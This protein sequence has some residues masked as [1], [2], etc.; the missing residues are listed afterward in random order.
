MRQARRPLPPK[1]LR[2]DSKSMCWCSPPALPPQSHVNQQGVRA[3]A[4]VPSLP[5]LPR[6]RHVDDDCASPASPPSLLFP[7]LVVL[8]RFSPVHGYCSP[9]PLILLPSQ[10][11]SSPFLSSSFSISDQTKNL[12]SS[13][14][15]FTQLRSP[16]SNRRHQNLP[17]LLSF[18]C[19]AA[20]ACSLT[21]S[22]LCP[23]NK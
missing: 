23:T 20:R 15:R 18:L 5:N 12:P 22:L 19:N 4:A 8:A 3:H 21:S 11:A 7:V 1:K 13:S 2:H 16:S 9:R 6:V 17:H 14:D 10:P